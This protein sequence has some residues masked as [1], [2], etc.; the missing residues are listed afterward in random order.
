MM[1]C[2]LS[3][4]SNIDTADPQQLNDMLQQCTAALTDP[5]LWI[6]SI[7]ITI[8]CALVGALIGKYKN[9]VVRDTILGAALGPIGWII[10]LL[11]P[12]QK[13][14]PICPACHKVLEIGD[15]HCRHCGAKLS[16]TQRVT[17][18]QGTTTK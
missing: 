15:V 8:A 13:P 6:W 10:S 11:L 14:K 17:G 5:G 3:S 18:G 2:D 7:V 1:A 12:A 16:G 9:A 4:L